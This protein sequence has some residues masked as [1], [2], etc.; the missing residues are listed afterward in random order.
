MHVLRKPLD[1]LTKQGTEWL[2]TEECQK[3]FESF[4]SILQSDLL[5]THYNPSNE[6]IVVGDAS[7]KGIG[8]CILHR[9]KDGSVNAI[10]HASR[11]LTNTE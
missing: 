7:S 9:F 5:L 4:K 1:D 11:T 10:Q 6:I 3:S 2:W 8:A